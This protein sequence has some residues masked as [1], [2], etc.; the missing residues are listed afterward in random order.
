MRKYFLIFFFSFFVVYLFAD[1][2]ILKGIFKQGGF[3]QADLPEY[4]TKCYFNDF[5]VPIYHNYIFVGLKKNQSFANDLIF[6]TVFGDT[7]SYYVEVKKTKY[8]TQKINKVP[9][10]Y[11]KKPKN[12]NLIK[13]INREYKTLTTVRKKIIYQDKNKYF[14]KFR[15]PLIYRISGDFGSERIL[16]GVKKSY[17][18]GVDFAAPKG[19]SVYSCANGIVSLTGDYFYNGKFVLINHGLGVS[20]IYIHLSKIDVIAGE[21]VQ[22]GKKIGEVGATGRA[23]GNHLHWGVYW[24]EFAIDPLLITKSILQEKRLPIER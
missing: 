1:E 14:N 17:H 8:K 15:L 18:K 19:A 7:L 21:Y 13:R 12:K 9:K 2:I 10:K 4:I 23:V 16:N 11:V 20:S 5:D 24:Y 6:V 3:F 22:I